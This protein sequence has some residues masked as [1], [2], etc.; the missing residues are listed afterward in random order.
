[1][2]AE[3]LIEVGK[4]NTMGFRKMLALLLS[5]EGRGPAARTVELFGWPI[6]IEGRLMLLVTRRLQ[7][8][9]TIRSERYL[10]V[11]ALFSRR[12]MG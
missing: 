11:G 2:N 8:A 3:G 7:G 12:M 10:P 5:A 1:M 4:M 9:W 6:M